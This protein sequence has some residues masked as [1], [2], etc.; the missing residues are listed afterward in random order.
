MGNGV[1][2]AGMSGTHQRADLWQTF[3]DSGSQRCQ[4]GGQQAQVEFGRMTMMTDAF[5]ISYTYSHIDSYTYINYYF[6]F[7]HPKKNVTN[8]T[9]KVY[10][11]YSSVTGMVNWD[12]TIP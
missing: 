2:D 11:V 6:E 4:T 9:W 10:S 1:E 8:I 12:E 5:I 7:F 3:P